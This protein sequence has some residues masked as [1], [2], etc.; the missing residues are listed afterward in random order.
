MDERRIKITAGSVSAEAV[1]NDSETSNLIWGKLPIESSA[2]TW[3]DEIYFSIPV[4]V[5]VGPDAKE[6]VEEGELGYWAPGTAFCIFFGAT[7][8]SRPGEIRPA[9]A[10]NPLGFIDGDPRV[11]KSVSGGDRVVIEKA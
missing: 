6:V 9:G 4:K 8:V 1:L 3:G 7:P 11:F 10:V 5:S 2:S